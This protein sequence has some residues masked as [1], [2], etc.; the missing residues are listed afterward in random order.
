M[1]EAKNSSAVTTNLQYE[2][3]FLRNSLVEQLCLSDSRNGKQKS[4]RW[5]FSYIKY[6]ISSYVTYYDKY[7]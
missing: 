5:K 2:S 7:I 6:W 1:V 4:G 3:F